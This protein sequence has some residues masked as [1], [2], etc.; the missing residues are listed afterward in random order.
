MTQ[1]LEIAMFLES[2]PWQWGA[3]G[4]LETKIIVGDLEF[5]FDLKTIRERSDLRDII[6][7]ARV[8]SN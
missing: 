1:G 3:S 2:L 5:I 4:N 8:W 7:K 6:A